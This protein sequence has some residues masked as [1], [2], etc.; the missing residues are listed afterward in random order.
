MLL[1]IGAYLESNPEAV[2]TLYNMSA[3]QPR[4]RALVNDEVQQLFQGANYD[5]LP[6]GGRV[7]IYPGDRE[8][9]ATQGLTV[10]F[11]NLT[12]RGNEFANVP[13]IAVWVPS[14]MAVDW[15]VQDS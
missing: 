11:H 12:A 6:G 8:I 14:E 1:Q 4:V 7:A 5:N 10:Q 13:T 9:R 15:L 3:G 2:C